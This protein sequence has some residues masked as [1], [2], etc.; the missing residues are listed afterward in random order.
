MNTRLP[1]LRAFAA[2]C[3]CAS[4]VAL[5]FCVPPR[6]PFVV[7]E[8]AVTIRVPV[9][10]LAVLASG[11]SLVVRQ[12]SITITI[13][14]TI[15]VEAIEPLPVLFS[16]L[17]AADLTEVVELG[18]RESA[19]SVGIVGVQ[20]VGT[21]AAGI[22]RQIVSERGQPQSE[23]IQC[24]DGGQEFLRLRHA[25]FLSKGTDSTPLHS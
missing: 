14:I 4:L 2:L 23:Q 15:G 16:S 12:T 10:K 13:T 3:A 7:T 17:F 21:A 8:R 20:D 11:S 22:R 1:S 25:V 5:Q 24:R 18:S 6:G 19:V 9:P